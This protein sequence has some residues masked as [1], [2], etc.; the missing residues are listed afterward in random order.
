[1]NHQNCEAIMI[2][3]K[4]R[5]FVQLKKIFRYKGIIFVEYNCNC[6]K[7][8]KKMALEKFI[9]YFSLKYKYILK[10]ST[11]L[12]IAMMNQKEIKYDLGKIN[13]KYLCSCNQVPIRLC[14]E[15]S[16]FLCKKCFK[17][18]Y[19]HKLLKYDEYE[20]LNKK[21]MDKF[22]KKAYQFYK[23]LLKC[24]L[25]VTKSLLNIT[26]NNDIKNESLFHHVCSNNY[27]NYLLYLLFKLSINS[28]KAFSNISNYLNLS[29]FSVFNKSFN[30]SSYETLNW[31]KEKILDSFIYY[32]QCSFL[33]PIESDDKYLFLIKELKFE[34]RDTP[35]LFSELLQ[36]GHL[37]D[38]PSDVIKNRDKDRFLRK[39]RK[40]KANNLIE[41]CKIL[42][43]GRLLLT[44]LKLND[45]Y[46]YPPDGNNGWKEIPD[47]TIYNYD[48]Y[49]QILE[50][51]NKYLIINFRLCVCFAELFDKSYKL[52]HLQDATFY[53]IQ[54]KNTK[55]LML[56]CEWF[57]VNTFCDNFKKTGKVMKT[58][59]KKKNKSCFT[60]AFQLQDGTVLVTS[61]IKIVFFNESC[62]SIF[63]EIILTNYQIGDE[64]SS[65]FENI[66]KHLLYLLSKGYLLVFDT[67]NYQLLTVYT[68]IT[69]QFKLLGNCFDFNVFLENNIHK[70][71]NLFSLVRADSLNIRGF[72]Q[73][74]QN[75]FLVF[76]N[77]QIFIY[78][79]L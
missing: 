74:S 24:N 26:Q 35:V 79:I 10:T 31:K 66:E 55:L 6:F 33:I 18:H 43:D 45:I 78:Q 52:Y 14:V 17:N 21:N 53:I 13:K 67:N 23:R 65:A 30:I 76:T 3:S 59:F 20:L 39:P 4:C 50:L 61:F 27:T 22:E 38:F 75:K 48:T 64:D 2:C 51:T 7:K 28:F 69:L 62:T 56:G 32:C 72:H 19:I 29:H 37:H 25:Y 1:M 68:G 71:S 12:K 15:C 54:L 49:K 40:K 36:R 47:I 63:Q 57:S 44:Y 41:W 16:K 5:F 60:F 73:I 58:H 77:E 42:S 8:N 34:H 70:F 11:K 46:I 9:N